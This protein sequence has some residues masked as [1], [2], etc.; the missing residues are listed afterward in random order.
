MNAGSVASMQMQYCTAGCNS[1]AI[2]KQRLPKSKR[3][4]LEAPKYPPKYI[5]SKFGERVISMVP[6]TFSSWGEFRKQTADLRP[7]AQTPAV[8][9][10][11]ELTTGSLQA[12]RAN[13]MVQKPLFPSLLTLLAR[14][15]SQLEAALYVHSVNGTVK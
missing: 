1:E 6:I 9:W 12:L 5:Y 10:S 4:V 15:S 7:A 13:M 14:V 2:R 11:T 8:S 3:Y